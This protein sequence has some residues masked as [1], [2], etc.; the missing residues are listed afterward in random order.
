MSEATLSPRPDWNPAPPDGSG[1]WEMYCYIVGGDDG[2]DLRWIPKD[3]EDPG[4]LPF[5]HI[6]DWPF[7]D[8]D[9]ATRADFEALGF[10]V[11]S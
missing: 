1:T 9:V 7:G 5:D 10:R 4:M 8:D 11:E 6:I 3:C 2:C